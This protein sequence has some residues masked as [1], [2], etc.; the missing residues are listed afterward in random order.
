SC[1]TS[2]NAA[3]YGRYLMETP[4]RIPGSRAAPSVVTLY[5]VRVKLRGMMV[6]GLSQSGRSPDIVR[7]IESA[8]DAG[9]TTVAITNDPRAPLARAADE[10]LVL[11]AGA[12]RSVAATKTYTAQLMLLSLL[13]AHAAGDSRLIRAHEA[14]PEAVA[15][16]LQT[17]PAV[18]GPAAVPHRAREPPGPP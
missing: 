15:R 1:G 6:I 4:L 11:H 8:R 13:V 7:V 2:G 3:R 14:L 16:A 18:A 17:A 9:A 5:G 10:V 12:E